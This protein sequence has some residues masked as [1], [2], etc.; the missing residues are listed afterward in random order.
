MGVS[1]CLWSRQPPSRPQSAG[2]GHQRQEKRPN[3]R[4]AAPGRLS[5]SPGKTPAATPGAARHTPQ[6]GCG[7]PHFNPTPPPPPLAAASRARWPQGSLARGGRGKSGGGRR[8]RPPRDPRP[9]VCP[10]PLP[11]CSPA[12]R[13]TLPRPPPARPPAHPPIRPPARPPAHPPARRSGRLSVCAPVCPPRASGLPL[14][15]ACLPPS[16]GGFAWRSFRRRPA[17]PQASPLPPLATRLV[18]RR[19]AHLAARPRCP[20]PPPHPPALLLV[21]LALCGRAPSL[22]PPSPL[23]PPSPSSPLLFPASLFPQR[24]LPVCPRLSRRVARVV[25]RRC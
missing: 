5:P 22:P 11:R 17:T 18:P 20:P 3:L 24:L 23:V 19:P 16:L 1:A 21:P 9:C 14:T 15:S 6:L 7:A 25:K 13:P 10:W 2:R 8:R 12:L 4:T